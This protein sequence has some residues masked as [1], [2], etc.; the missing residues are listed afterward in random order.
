MAGSCRSASFAL[1][2]EQELL[3]IRLGVSYLNLNYG[4]SYLG[5]NY[6]TEWT[7]DN[8]VAMTSVKL[9]CQLLFV[10]SDTVAMSKRRRR[11]G[12]EV[13]YRRVIEDPD[14]THETY[15]SE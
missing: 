13:D 15:F 12:Q 11:V 9:P 1:H 8:V 6:F 4:V 7:N 3:A 2:G 10:A 5:L 14:W